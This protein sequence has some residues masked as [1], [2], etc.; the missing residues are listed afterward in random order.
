MPLPVCE[1]SEPGGSAQTT[2]CNQESCIIHTE[3]EIFQVLVAVERWGQTVKRPAVLLTLPLCCFHINIFTGTFFWQP[4]LAPR[5]VQR[6]EGL[7]TTCQ[8]YALESTE[9]QGDL[10]S[11]PLLL[12]WCFP[13][14]SVSVLY[15]LFKW[16]TAGLKSSLC[17]NSLPTSLSTFLPPP[18]AKKAEAISETLILLQMFLLITK[19]LN[20]AAWWN[21]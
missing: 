2:S 12:S 6:R 8:R 16:E 17:P 15:P 13:T 21:S 5:T 9:G 18:L 20:L 1:G 4:R 7:L 3:R 10:I 19:K 11:N 14:D